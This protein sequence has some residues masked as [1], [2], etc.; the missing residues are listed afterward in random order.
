MPSTCPVCGAALVR[1]EDEA[2]RR[3]ENLQCA[4]Q[5]WGRICHFAGRDAMD[6]DHLGESTAT[7]LLDQKLVEDAADVF[8]LTGAQIGSLPGFKDKSVKNLLAAI[9]AAKTRPIDRLLVALGIRHVG[10]SAA[11]ALAD[12]FASIDAIASATEEDLAPGASAS[13]ARFSPRFGSS[14]APRNEPSSADTTSTTHVG[15]RARV[16]RTQPNARLTG[17]NQPT[18]SS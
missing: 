6:I 2:V 10:K 3:C 9:E 17:P 4:A 1:G 13:E 16:V 7:L 12:H 18:T 11:V 15:I 5:T 14:S 8:F